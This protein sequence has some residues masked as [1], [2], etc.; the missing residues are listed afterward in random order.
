VT[1]EI[2]DVIKVWAVTADQRVLCYAREG[3]NISI[4]RLPTWVPRLAGDAQQV[5][6]EEGF[7]KKQGQTNEP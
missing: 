3:L 7:L 5:R 2:V 6:G 4:G 1:E